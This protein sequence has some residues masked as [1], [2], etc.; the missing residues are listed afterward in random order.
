MLGNP[1]TGAAPWARQHL[2]FWL[3]LILLCSF[4]AGADEPARL[5]LLIGNQ[6]YA[7]KVGPLK[8]PLHDVS[9]IEASLKKLGFKVTVLKDAN[10]KAMDSA[11]KRY[12]REVN[13]AGPGAISFFYYS[14]HGVANPETKINYLIPV[15]VS[16]PQDEKIWD[17]SLQQNA[18]IDLLSSQASR[19]THFVVFDACRNELNITGPAA[20]ALGAEKGFLPILNTSGLLI[21][22]ATAPNKTASDSGSDGG[23][24]AKILADELIKPGL[25]AVAMFR[26]VQIRVKQSI[27]QDPWLSFPSLPPIYLAGRGEQGPA[28]SIQLQAGW[29]TAEREWQQYGKD[30]NDIRL[31]EAFKEKHKADPLYVRLAEA[32]IEELKRRQV[33]STT[34]LPRPE[35]KQTPSRCDGIE[36]AVGQSERRCFKP[37][38]GKTEHFKD[39]ETCPEM[40]VVP[41]GRFTM[42]SPSDEPERLN[43]EDQVQVAIAKPFA[44]GRH[45][46]TRGEFAAFVAATGHRMDGGCT[47]WTGSEWK[48]Q[49]DHNWRSPEFSETDR[50]PVV[51]VNW[52]DAKAYVAW[53]ASTTG[54]SYRLLSEAERE[55]VTRAGTTTPFWWGTSI[56]ISQ[57][58][59]LD[60]YKYGSGSKDERREA[61]VPVDS[62]TAN[63]WGLFNVHGNV[64]EWTEDCWSDKNAGNPGDGTA[65]SS[66]YCTRR[67]LRGGSWDLIPRLLR[68][69]SR[70]RNDPA[71]RNISLGFR[72]ARTL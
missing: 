6:A 52:N 41:T 37:G 59:Y 51:C 36:I 34:P 15:D 69:A 53:L 3:A 10:Y 33:A 21:A 66:G 18:V 48:L 28:T 26:A 55:Y 67:V 58:N 57:A 70:S 14:G 72:V 47:V 32:R 9:L 71:N 65:R 16:D 43:N 42:G 19:A 56:S 62:F 60:I 5:A 64:W 27:G 35:T 17:E 1:V 11:I 22:Y 44:V 49:T 25:E 30:T 23:P 7:A 29:S 68:S 20:K 4:P 63:P 46:L 45:A 50:H 2:P 12:V 13:R 8:N 61:T 24:Y 40:V 38:A 31:L 54:E 39:C